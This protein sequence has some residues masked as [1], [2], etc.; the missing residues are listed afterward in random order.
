[1]PMAFSGGVRVRNRSPLGEHLASVAANVICVSTIVRPPIASVSHNVIRNM[2]FIAVPSDHHCKPLH[3]AYDSEYP[4]TGPLSPD[5]RYWRQYHLTAG[6]APFAF[7][8]G[9][10]GSDRDRHSTEQFQHSAERDVDRAS[11]LADYPH[12]RAIMHEIHGGVEARG[13][14][15]SDRLWRSSDGQ[16]V[17]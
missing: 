4:L 16:R 3:L 10:G 9:S 7:K 11:A 5:S 1:M 15:R 13:T 12:V 6:E 2:A 17:R 8:T 14:H